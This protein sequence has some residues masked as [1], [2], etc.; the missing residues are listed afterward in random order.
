MFN[1]QAAEAVPL[2]VISLE[3]RLYQTK[4]GV[5]RSR[6][7]AATRGAF[8]WRWTITR[9]MTCDT[10]EGQRDSLRV[11]RAHMRA[12]N[13]LPFAQK[14]FTEVT[15]F[16]DTEFHQIYTF[17][18]CMLW[19]CSIDVISIGRID[20]WQLRKQP[21]RSSRRQPRRPPR[22]SNPTQGKR[23][24]GDAMSVPRSA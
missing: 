7:E 6:I 21:R 16:L 14:K 19:S 20:T 15:I 17:V 3:A 22:R 4:R 23:R 11:V 13:V 5:H 24:T 2:L 1:S 10:S 12:S 18:S 8:R 9:S